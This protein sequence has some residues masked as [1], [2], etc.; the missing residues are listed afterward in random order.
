MRDSN[1]QSL[2][3]NT[4]IW[5]KLVGNMSKSFKL[6]D[7]IWKKIHLGGHFIEISPRYFFL[8]NSMQKVTFDKFTRSWKNVRKNGDALFL[9][10][11]NAKSHFMTISPNRRKM[12]EKMGGGGGFSY[13]KLPM[14]FDLHIPS[15]VPHFAAKVYFLLSDYYPTVPHFAAKIYFLLPDYYPTTTL[16]QLQT[17]PYFCFPYV[18]VMP[19]FSLIL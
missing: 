3:A 18:I 7:D 19:D 14:R 2:V 8:Q 5:K 10:N 1:Q 12:S 17:R 11:F 13:L 9:A 6:K 16:R 15:S 4:H